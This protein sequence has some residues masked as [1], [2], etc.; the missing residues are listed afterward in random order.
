MKLAAITAAAALLFVGSTAL[1][2]VPKVGQP[3]PDFTITLRTGERLHL[4]DLKGQVVVLNF[5]ATWCV[6][7]RKELPLLDSY[8][9]AMKPHGLRVL[10][11]T[12]EDSL[13]D[14]QLKPLFATLTIEPIR[15]VKGPYQ[16]IDDGVPT[17]YII[18]RAG[19]IRYAKPGALTLDVL[20]QELVPLL[21]EPPPAPG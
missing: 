7:C 20:N 12:T 19:R 11:I 3:A 15:G 13:S 5:W 14:A 2:K 21:N 9:K 17:S 10:A 4:A 18:D 8:Y 6:P 1:A 16:P